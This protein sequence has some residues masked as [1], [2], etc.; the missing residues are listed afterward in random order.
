MRF[1]GLLLGYVPQTCKMNKLTF[2]IL[3]V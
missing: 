3:H 1:G 2:A